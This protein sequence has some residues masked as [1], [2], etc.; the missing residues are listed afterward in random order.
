MGRWLDTSRWLRG[1]K[2]SIQSPFHREIDMGRP[3]VTAETF[4]NRV[5]RGNVDECWP[6]FGPTSKS[7]RGVAP[8]GR[9][10][11]FGFKGVYVHRIAYWLA[12]GGALSLRKDGDLLVRHSCDNTLCCNPAH[13]E[14]GTHL[15]NMRDSV[16]RKRRP[17]Y[18]GVRGPRAKLIEHDVRQIRLQTKE[19][20]TCR[21]L[22]L[23]YDVSRSTIQGVLYGRHYQDVI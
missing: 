12:N 4:W 23:L 21:A 22:Q 14:L 20:A 16:S 19:G 2:M 6:W 3:S 5:R 15:D 11:A 10:D 18:R 13:L 8:Y 7:K 1:L 17:D 9:V